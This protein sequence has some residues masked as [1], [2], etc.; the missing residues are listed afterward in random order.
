M[1]MTCAE[2]RHDLAVLAKL[3]AA[4]RRGNSSGAREAKDLRWAA[5]QWQALSALLETRR[6]LQGQKVVSLAQWCGEPVPLDLPQ[7]EATT[8]VA[9]PRQRRNRKR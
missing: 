7:G 9:G 4:I 8:R 5:E 1:A 3:I 2:L 6:R